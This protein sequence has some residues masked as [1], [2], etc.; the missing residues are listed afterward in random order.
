M[1]IIVCCS[2][3]HAVKVCHAWKLV[4]HDNW[5]KHTYSIKILWLHLFIGA[6]AA[7]MRRIYVTHGSLYSMIIHLR[8]PKTLVAYSR[9]KAVNFSCSFRNIGLQHKRRRSDLYTSPRVRTSRRKALETI[10]FNRTISLEQLLQR[11]LLVLYAS[12]SINKYD[13]TWWIFFKCSRSC[14]LSLFSKAESFCATTRA[15]VL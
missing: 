13:A 5:P 2:N 14:T 4:F 9:S 15:M 12:A 11:R 8:F 10:P 7:P 3:T 1:N 6:A